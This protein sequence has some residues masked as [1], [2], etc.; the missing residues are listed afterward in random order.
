MLS[1]GTRSLLYG[2]HQFIL[3]PIAV[4]AAYWKLYGPILDLRVWIAIVIHDWGYWGLPEMDGPIGDRHPEWAARKMFKWFGGYWGSFTLYHSRFLAKQDGR[5]ISR[6]CV[7]DKFSHCLF[8]PKIYLFIISLTGE[9]EEYMGR[10]RSS[11][12]QN[13]KLD[14]STPLSWHLGVC[15]WL[16]KWVDEYKDLRPD[17]WTPGPSIEEGNLRDKT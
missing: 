5:G 1:I 10:A 6:L 14:T 4:A 13:M 12:Y 9:L 2:G 15:R 3:H 17:L 8:P 16:R 7:A 11:K